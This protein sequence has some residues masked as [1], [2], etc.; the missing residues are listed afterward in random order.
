MERCSLLD[1][2]ISI[3]HHE[4][5]QAE[6]PRQRPLPASVARSEGCDDSITSRR[7]LFAVKQILAKG[8]ISSSRLLQAPLATTYRFLWRASVVIPGI[9]SFHIV[10]LGAR[11]D[12]EG[13]HMRRHRPA[14]YGTRQLPTRW[15]LTPT[16]AGKFSAPRR[17]R[18]LESPYTPKTI[19][20]T[21]TMESASVA[22]PAWSPAA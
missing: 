19:A 22:L 8:W 7:P 11:A 20:G 2:Y 4:G 6:V 5:N 13:E 21:T 12:Q 1:V 17:P 14:G 15:T 3:V 18:R 16:S 9:T 10:F